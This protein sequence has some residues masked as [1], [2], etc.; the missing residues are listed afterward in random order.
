MHPLAIIVV[1]TAFTLSPIF[2]EPIKYPETER[3]D[4]TETLHGVEVPDP[5]RWLEDI[6]SEAVQDWVEKQAAFAGDFL[7]KL[8]GRDLLER[9]LTELWDYEKHGLPYQMGGRLF[10]TRNTGLQNQSV[11]YWKED[12]EGAEEKLLLDPNALSED[13]TVAL[14]GYSISEDGK[15]L[16]YGISKSGS[17]WQEWKVREIATAR[18]TGDVLQHIKFSSAEWSPD[19]QGLVYS[20]YHP[21]EAG[22]LKESNL[23]QKVYYHRLGDAQEKDKLI[24]ERPDEPQWILNGSYTED[25]RYLI[26][27]VSTGAGSKNGLFY[28]DL[29][30]DSSEFI[31]L[32][33]PDKA[34]YT[35]VDNDGPRF[36]LYTDDGAPSGRFIVVDT[37]NPERAHWRELIP[38]REDAALQGVSGVGDVFIADYLKDVLPEVVVLD[39]EGKKLREVPMSELGSVS[40]FG[41]RRE[42]TST[43]YSLSGY[44]NPGRLYRYDLASGESSLYWEADLRFNPDDFVTKREFYKSKDGTRIPLFIVHRNDVKLDGNAPTFLYG[45]GGFDISLTPRFQISNLAWVDQGGVFA[46]ANLRGGGEYGQAWHEAG[47]KEKKQNVF[48]DFIAAA[49][50]L[51]ANKVTRP[52]KLAIGGGSNGGLL[53]A[54]CMN[55]RPEL[56]GACWSA[57]GVQDMLRFHKFT[58]GWAWQDEYGDAEKE[59]DFKNLLSYSPYHNIKKGVSYP[60]VLITTADHDD[61]VFPAHSF[62][63]GAALQHAQSGAAPIILRIETKAGHGAGKPTAKVIEE[64]AD[65]WAF[66]AHALEFEIK[67]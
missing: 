50:W 15:Y 5:Y 9:R 24:Y 6:D 51:I 40:G 36:Y 46:L 23:N 19:H 32:L 13:G 52:E 30:A 2:A 48:D 45:Y 35:L 20:R 4:F 11:L 59:E 44:T 53:T 34:R 41:G 8:P 1:T 27:T 64:V 47:M 18:D 66:L 16:A 37:G 38:E 43:F 58:I 10:Y 22:D 29:Q 33:Q 12:K 56:F 39:R 49:E 62:K 21:S 57:V 60:P 7:K 67:N 28:R 25:G 14:S 42:D 61:R 3:T 55:Q 31:E 17:D 65:R 63:Y 54:A 26:I